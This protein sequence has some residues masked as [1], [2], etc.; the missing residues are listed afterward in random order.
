MAERQLTTDQMRQMAEYLRTKGYT[1]EQIESVLGGDPSE[2]TAAEN[3]HKMSQIP[4][5]EALKND[6]RNPFGALGNALSGYIGGREQKDYK[7]FA[8]QWKKAALIRKRTALDMANPQMPEG[9]VELG[10]VTPSMMAGMAGEE[11]GGLPGLV[12]GDEE[13]E[14]RRRIYGG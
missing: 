1:Q 10:G 2:A 11:A 13:E 12:A 5:S 4:I 8:N 3:I 7:D 6:A 14:R 9:P